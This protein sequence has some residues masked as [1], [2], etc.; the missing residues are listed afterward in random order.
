MQPPNEQQLIAQAQRGDEAAVS[1][2]YEM[3]VD[4]IFTYMSYRVDSRTTAED[5]TSDVFVRM[6]RGLSTYNDKGL[7]FRA[8]LYRI[9]HSRLVDYYRYRDRH[10]TAPLTENRVNDDTDPLDR[11]ARTEEQLRLRLAI[12]ELSEEYQTLL[13]LRFVENL[14]HTEIA[15]IMNKSAGN[16]RSMQHRALKALSTA[17]DK[18]DENS[19]KGGN[20]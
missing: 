6:V 10:V 9:A 3:H 13:V 1:L 2:L 16:L 20:K 15:V 12:R 5:L 7:P 4:A 11:I 17:F 14:S 8:W 19:T 18:L